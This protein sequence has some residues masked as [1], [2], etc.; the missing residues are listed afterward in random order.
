MEPSL[1]P[2]SKLNTTE[3][4]NFKIDKQYKNKQRTVF[5]NADNGSRK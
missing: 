2:I 5:Y 1:V 4:A 3:L